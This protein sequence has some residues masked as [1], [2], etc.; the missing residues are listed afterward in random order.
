[1]SADDKLYKFRAHS[2]DELK[3]EVAEY[4]YVKIKQNFPEVSEV[5]LKQPQG[6]IHILICSDNAQIMPMEKCR[7]NQMILY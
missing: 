5:D 1:M 4:D 7:K 2:V 3:I 6:N